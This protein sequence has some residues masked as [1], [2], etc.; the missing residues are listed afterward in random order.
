MGG[1]FTLAHVGSASARSRDAQC[2]YALSRHSRSHAGSFFFSQ[3][4]RTTSSFKPFWRTSC[5][6]SVTKPYLYS[7]LARA[8]MV[9]VDV[10]IASPCPLP[11]PLRS[12]V[13]AR[14]Q[15][16]TAPT[17]KLRH[18]RLEEAAAQAHVTHT[19]LQQRSDIRLLPGGDGH[20]RQARRQLLGGRDQQ[21]TVDTGCL[22]VENHQVRRQRA[23]RSQ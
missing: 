6:I 10:L 15:D 12:S 21:Q 13:C 22:Q 8:S 9:S 3:I 16:P 11:C 19:L 14:R 2:R 4:V 1:Y 18:E 20:D 5:S 7:R 23:D 17:G